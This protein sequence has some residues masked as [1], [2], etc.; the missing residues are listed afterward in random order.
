MK[1]HFYGIN[2]TA[3]INVSSVSEDRNI[4]SFNNT[5]L[6]RQMSVSGVRQSGVAQDFIQIGSRDPRLKGQAAQNEI[7]NNF[8]KLN[9]AAGGGTNVNVAPEVANAVI[10]GEAFQAQIQLN[11][12]DRRNLAITGLATLIQ[13][14]AALATGGNSGFNKEQGDLLTGRASADA[15]FVTKYGNKYDRGFLGIGAQYQDATITLIS[16]QDREQLESTIEKKAVDAKIAALGAKNIGSDIETTEDAEAYKKTLGVEAQRGKY[17]DTNGGGTIEDN[18]Y[19]RLGET[20]LKSLT[21]EQLKE[22]KISQNELNEIVSKISNGQKL[23]DNQISKLRAIGFSIGQDN[24]GNG[25]IV[26]SIIATEANLTAKGVKGDLARKSTADYLLVAGA[27]GLLTKEEKKLLEKAIEQSDGKTL[28]DLL[29]EVETRINS[30]QYA[31]GTKIGDK[32]LSNFKKDRLLGGQHIT[33]LQ[34]VA[35][36]RI[37]L[38]T[39]AADQIDNFVNGRGGIL[40]DATL[41]I[42]NEA[43]G[44][45]I[46]TPDELKALLSGGNLTGVNNVLTKITDN[47]EEVRSVLTKKTDPEKTKTKENL[48]AGGLYGTRNGILENTLAKTDRRDNTVA[49]NEIDFFT[50]VKSLSDLVKYRQE[51]GKGDAS[52]DGLNVS[53]NGSIAERAN[54]LKSEFSAGTIS[55]AD[56]ERISG[57]LAVLFA[58]Q[59]KANGID[60]TQDDVQSLVKAIAKGDTNS[61]ILTK[62]NSADLTN[63]SLKYNLQA[64]VDLEKSKKNPEASP[65]TIVS[66][67]RNITSNARAVNSAYNDPNINERAT[68]APSPVNAIKDGNAIASILDETGG[69]QDAG[70]KLSTDQIPQPVANQNEFEE[71]KEY[72]GTPLAELNR[73]TEENEKNNTFTDEGVQPRNQIQA[74][75]K[76]VSDLL[77]KQFVE[78]DDGKKQTLSDAI[79]MAL[80]KIADEILSKSKANYS[81][82]FADSA[83]VSTSIYNNS[84]TPLQELYASTK[85]VGVGLQNGIKQSDKYLRRRNNEKEAEGETVNLRD[86]AAKFKTEAEPV[87]DTQAGEQLVKTAEEIAE[88]EKARRDQQIIADNQVI[89]TAG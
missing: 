25:G 14:G 41:K 3:N 40:S 84:K 1:N 59:L 54:A 85:A 53:T 19:K 33:E 23:K 74:F 71:Y 73:K 60:A 24:G 65:N 8:R 27:S 89:V 18:A 79:V 46:K 26:T 6:Q 63:P 50:G 20:Y 51:G 69:K 57:E 38:N 48:V 44:T 81:Y 88:E 30:N 47:I 75:A 15:E 13:L 77:D 52:V 83:G 72:T 17:I 62:V 34:Y 7:N 82:G 61:P 49:P 36:Q 29:G 10:R 4:L 37:K 45:N 35:N 56:Q 2:R 55:S 12:P 78:G 64:L 5:K 32:D 9:E 28:S 22:A 86:A 21:P 87:T 67:S 58:N 42:F 39:D 70:G 76:T 16:S 66:A 68:S 31:D 11:A 80:L 43:N